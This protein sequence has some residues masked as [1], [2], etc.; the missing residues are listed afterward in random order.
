MCEGRGP[1]WGGDYSY[2]LI[3]ENVY[4]NIYSQ[5]IPHPLLREISRW[6]WGRAWSGRKGASV[7][8]TVIQ[9]EKCQVTLC[10]GIWDWFSASRMYYTE[11][12]WQQLIIGISTPYVYKLSVSVNCNIRKLILFTLFYRLC[13]FTLKA[14]SQFKLNQ[15]LL[16]RLGISASL[17]STLYSQ[18]F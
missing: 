4:R 18:T 3:F 6:E 16:W 11:A 2:V 7:S 5:D 13:A 14:F 1:V 15:N 12:S 10:C 9:I 17:V 8:R